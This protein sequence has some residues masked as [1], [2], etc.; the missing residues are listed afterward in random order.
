MEMTFRRVGLRGRP[1]QTMGLKG[2]RLVDGHGVVPGRGD[3]SSSTTAGDNFGES[4]A[5][6]GHLGW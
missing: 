6:I 5:E 2:L 3:V 4:D 1:K